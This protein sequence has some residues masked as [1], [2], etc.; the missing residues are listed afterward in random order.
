[1]NFFEK[2]FSLLFTT[3]ETPKVFG[4]YHILWLVIKN[5]GDV[6]KAKTA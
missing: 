2:A 6:K 1:M 4:W 3:V 5:I